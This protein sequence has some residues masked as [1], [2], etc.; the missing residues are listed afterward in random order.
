MINFR[1]YILVVIL[2]VILTGCEKPTLPEGGFAAKAS[3]SEQQ[4]KVGD[5]TTLTFTARHEAGS[6]VTFPVPGKGKELVVRGRSGDTTE[7]ADGI[8]QTEEIYYLTSLRTGNWLITTNAAV[9]TFADG[10]KKAQALPPLTLDVQSSLD[11]NNKNS[12]SDIKGPIKP[13]LQIS[14]ILWVLSV[15][16]ILALLGGLITLLIMKKGEKS[17]K[18]E[19]DLPAH[20]KALTALS[21]LK[22]RPWMPE[23]FFVDLSLILRTY[24][25]DRFSLNAPDSTTEE[26]AGQLNHDTRLTLKDQNTLREFFVQADLVKFARAGAEKDVMRTAFSTVEEFVNQTT[27]EEHLPQENAKNSKN[28]DE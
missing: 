3:L 14:P 22:E 10:S 16:A 15:I 12:L 24:L 8:L 18:S 6:V 4:I 23:P 26:L 1:Q 19:P 17:A 9:C 25:E 2:A 13:P 7:L 28:E 20:I 27:E 21:A 11:E 5:I